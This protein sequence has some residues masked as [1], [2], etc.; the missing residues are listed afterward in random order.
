MNWESV[1]VFIGDKEIE[2]ISH[3]LYEPKPIIR[4]KPLWKRLVNLPY[5]WYKYN[6]KMNNMSLV[7]RITHLWEM[8]KIILK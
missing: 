2:G 8:T 5:V 3:I 4:V 7:D 1:K 6:Q